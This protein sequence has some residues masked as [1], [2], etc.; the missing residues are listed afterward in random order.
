MGAKSGEWIGCVEPS[1]HALY[2]CRNFIPSIPAVTFQVGVDSIGVSVCN[3]TNGSG[4][5]L[6]IF[7][8]A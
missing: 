3:P 7:R 6:Q 1:G 8:P 2:P 4:R 5:S